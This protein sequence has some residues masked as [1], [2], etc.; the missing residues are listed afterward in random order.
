MKDRRGGG[1]GGA[2]DRAGR[3]VSYGWG[4]RTCSSSALGVG[5]TETSY[6]GI[7]CKQFG[8]MVI[9]VKADLKEIPL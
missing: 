7:I 2:G 8:T 6:L 3:P 1:G 4:S 9:T 5:I